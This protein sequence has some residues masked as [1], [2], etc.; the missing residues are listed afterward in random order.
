MTGF[1]EIYFHKE[2]LTVIQTVQVV[3]LWNGFK[4]PV[5]WN[6]WTHVQLP[7]ISDLYKEVVC[8]LD[9]RLAA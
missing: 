5:L 2:R 9:P 3:L 8:T 1:T 7:N 4:Y 6:I